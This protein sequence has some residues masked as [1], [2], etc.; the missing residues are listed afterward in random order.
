MDQLLQ[1]ELSSFEAEVHL[2]LSEINKADEITKRII[3]NNNLL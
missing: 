1:D 3:K 2:K